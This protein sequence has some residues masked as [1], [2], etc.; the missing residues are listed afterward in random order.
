MK[1]LPRLEL[2][3]EQN[4]DSKN[5]YIIFRNEYKPGK[6]STRKS[7]RKNQGTKKRRHR[8]GLFNIF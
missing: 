6:K 2:S 3:K 1:D 5:E 7:N 8:K 4:S